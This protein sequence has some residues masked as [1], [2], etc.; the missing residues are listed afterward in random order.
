MENKLIKSNEPV[1]YNDYSDK[2]IIAIMIII[3]LMKTSTA[4]KQ[5]YQCLKSCKFVM[6]DTKPYRLLHSQTINFSLYFLG[7]LNEQS[8]DNFIT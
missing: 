1:F 5:I 8:H 2:F 7:L 6:C 4:N 3:I